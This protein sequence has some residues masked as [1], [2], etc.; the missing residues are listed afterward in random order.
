[1]LIAPLMT[2]LMG[3]AI[4]LVMGWP[5]RV[6]RS[7]IIAVA[8]ITLAIAIGVAVGLIS[9]TAVDTATNSQ[10]LARTSPTILDLGIALA[11]GAAGAYGLSRPD[12]SDSLPG[13]AIAISLVPPLTVVGLTLSQGSFSQSSGALLLFLTNM[14]AI[15]LMGGVVFVVTGVTPI[16]RLA[17][18]QHRVRTAFGAIGALGALVLGALLLNG[19]QVARDLAETDEVQEG[20]EAWLEPFPNHNLVEITTSADDVVIA[21][22]LGPSEDPPTALGLAEELA[23]RLD[24]PVQA[25]VRLV[26]EERD[27]ATAEPTG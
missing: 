18:N 19:A 10:I 17:D 3:M 8:G 13:V 12:V 21:I 11:A 5:V 22:V 27:T 1:M 6:A 20:A 15:L 23:D 4:S 2:P 24:R 26:V 7:T 9:P 14:I 16:Q 25:T